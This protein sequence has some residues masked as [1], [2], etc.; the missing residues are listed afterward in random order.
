MSNKFRKQETS[1]PVDWQAMAKRLQARV[2]WLERKRDY[3]K[4]VAKSYQ[5]AARELYLWIRES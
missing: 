3:W 1:Q 5:S 4:D 2:E